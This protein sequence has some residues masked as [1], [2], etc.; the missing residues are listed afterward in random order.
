MAVLLDILSQVFQLAKVCVRNQRIHREI[1]CGGPGYAEGKPLL[2]SSSKSWMSRQAEYYNSYLQ[3]NLKAPR[4]TTK[5]V[6]YGLFNMV[7]EA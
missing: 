2:K 6:E 4:Y 1:Q 7:N 3:L 5:L